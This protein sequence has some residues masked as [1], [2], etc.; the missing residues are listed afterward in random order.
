MMK[1]SGAHHESGSH[2]SFMHQAQHQQVRLPAGVPAV[3]INLQEQQ[4]RVCTSYACVRACAC[5][6]LCTPRAT[7]RSTCHTCTTLTA[8]VRAFP[9]CPRTRPSRPR[10]RCGACLGNAGSTH[11]CAPGSW[12]AFPCAA[13]GEANGLSDNWIA[14]PQNRTRLAWGRRGSSWARLN[15]GRPGSGEAPAVLLLQLVL[16]CC[17]AVLCCAVLCCA[18]LRLPSPHSPAR[19]LLRR[20]VPLSSLKVVHVHTYTTPHTLIRAR[21][22][23]A[24]GRQEEQGTGRAPALIPG[25]GEGAAEPLARARTPTQDKPLRHLLTQCPFAHVVEAHG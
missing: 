10:P 22:R 23:L 11:A 3:R 5:E 13:P 18:V 19:G 25:H 20:H 2:H 16:L 7:L 12:P 17:C 15:R 8:S 24:Q 21:A 14:C 4:P 1:K 6:T 9:W